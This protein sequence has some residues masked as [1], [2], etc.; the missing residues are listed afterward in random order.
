MPVSLNEPFMSANF[1]LRAFIAA[2]AC[3][4]QLASSSQSKV[5]TPRLNVSTSPILRA[6]CDQTSRECAS[7]CADTHRVPEATDTERVLHFELGAGFSPQPTA[8]TNVRC[9]P[10]T[11]AQEP[12]QNR[13]EL[14]RTGQCA[15]VTHPHCRFLY[16]SAIFLS[17]SMYSLRHLAW[18]SRMCGRMDT[19][20][21]WFSSHVSFSRSAFT[22]CK[23]RRRFQSVTSCK[24]RRRIQSVTSC[25]QR[26]RIQS[27]T[28]C[29]HRRRF[30]SVT[31]CKQRRRFQSVTSYKQKRYGRGPE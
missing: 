7:V 17:T 15:L 4:A 16:L 3:N 8:S 11:S 28:S 10:P 30:Q 1:I 31:S 27:V 29:K 23:H 21:S 26:R 19:T 20:H 5:G 12:E 14:Y 22:S 24:Q 25:T 13:S 6:S 9:A 2:I 18:Q